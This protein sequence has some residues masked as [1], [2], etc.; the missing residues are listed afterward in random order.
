M[1]EPNM[2]CDQ[3]QK[4]V[5]LDMLLTSLSKLEPG[6][7][8]RPLGHHKNVAALKNSAEAGCA[9]CKLVFGNI[10]TLSNNATAVIGQI[11]FRLN[12]RDILMFDTETQSSSSKGWPR[13]FCGIRLSALEG[14]R[15]F[16]TSGSSF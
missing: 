3:C 16:I 8:N 10:R 13:D 12:T 1:N 15:H 14:M 6:A 7:E 9:I 5:N 11:N 4:I 2:F